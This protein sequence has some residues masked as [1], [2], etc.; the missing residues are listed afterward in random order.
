MNTIITKKVTL[1]PAPFVGTKVKIHLDDN[2]LFNVRGA[3]LADGRTSIKVEWGDGTTEDFN[4]DLTAAAHTYPAPG[5]YIISISDDVR[6]FGIGGVTDASVHSSVY[7]PMVIE[8]VSNAKLLTLLPGYA[9]NNCRNMTLFDVNGASVSAIGIGA[10]KN[11]VSLDGELFF[12]KVSDIQGSASKMPF[13]G[14]TGITALHFAEEH[15]EEIKASEPYNADENHTLGTGVK[16]VCQ[17][18]L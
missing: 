17:F 7:A 12:P 14:C 18:D 8:I 15:Q 16:D 9:F 1:L 2:L 6:N 4:G 10:F 3:K 11:C 5:D 13:S